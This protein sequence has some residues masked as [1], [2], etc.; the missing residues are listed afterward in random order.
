MNNSEGLRST[1][2]LIHGLPKVFADTSLPIII[3]DLNGV[4]IAMNP[5][6]E[7]AYSWLSSELIGLPIK[8]I[9]PSSHHSQADRLLSSCRS[10][11]LI[12]DVE[13]VRQSKCGT[14]IPVLLTLSLLRD[15]T[16]EQF[17]ASMA[18]DISAIKEA[19]HKLRSYQDTLEAR[20]RERTAELEETLAELHQARLGADLAN[21]AKSE[22]LANMS[23]EIRTPMNAILGMTHLCLETDLSR[24]QRGY[25]QRINRSAKDLLGLVDDI[26]DFSKI[27]AGKLHLEETSFT[28]DS[29]LEKQ[30]DLFGLQASEKGIE[31]VFQVEPSLPPL[32]KGDPLRVGQILT[33]LLS[34]ALKFTHNGQVLLNVSAASSS[35]LRFEVRDTGIGVKKDLIE[36]IFESFCQ[37]DTSTTRRYGGTGLGLAIC[38]QLV[39]LM[40][41]TIGAKSVPGKGSQFWFELELEGFEE[42]RRVKSE[43]SKLA[44]VLENQKAS[45][46]SLVQFLHS[47]GWRVK[48][49]ASVPSVLKALSGDVTPVVLVLSDRDELN[50]EAVQKF[51]LKLEQPIPT[52]ILTRFSANTTDE[53]ISGQV[54]LK[55]PP[56]R[57]LLSERLSRVL[58]GDQEATSSLLP[59]ARLADEFR[60]LEGM[61]LLVAEDNAINRDVLR[62]ML[63][64]VGAVTTEAPSGEVA[65]SLVEDHA[66]D[67]ILMDIQMPGI[68]GVEA[69]RILRA[70]GHEIP[71]VAVTANLSQANMKEYRRAGIHSF[72]AKPIEPRDLYSLLLGLKQNR[73]VLDK[74]LALRMLQGNEDL[75]HELLHRFFQE[76]EENLDK[77]RSDSETARKVAH[78]LAS[79]AG[80]LGMKEVSKICQELEQ[81]ASNGEDIGTLF[82]RLKSAI[83]K[84]EN[85][86]TDRR[87]EEIPAVMRFPAEV[88]EE[89]DPTLILQK[90]K[91]GDVQAASLVRAYSRSLEPAESQDWERLVRL[92]E[93]YEFVAAVEWLEKRLG[94]R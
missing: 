49:F 61:E 41:G 37:V 63:T 28:L 76:T 52:L 42:R 59:R 83:K 29:L 79:T 25:L 35:V 9:V 77:I 45:R 51:C 54:S 39:R 72:L 86:Y 43:D 40:G 87:S 34:N 56:T 13:G 82:A 10:G 94:L 1:T 21:R 65:L 47:L 14:L 64:N 88:L 81:V 23:H 71:I 38:Q 73:R 3:E 60:A 33:N 68:D 80:T 32:Y 67:A 91:S 46:Q 22:F 57:S 53:T 78:T 17:I 12:R 55:R 69:S 62:D 6:A 48:A 70:R 89:L 8:T 31:L 19:E 75:F 4:V 92:V 2:T 26:L 24:K 7:E 18:T 93:D 85:A 50:L 11:K 15:E 66:F 58:S 44:F 27:E 84:A 36:S 90:L 16:G 5:A 74:K 30:R 20:V